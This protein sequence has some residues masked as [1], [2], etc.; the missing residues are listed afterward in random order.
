MSENT[1]PRRLFEFLREL[2]WLSVKHGIVI[3]GR[4]ELEFRDSL[5]GGYAINPNNEGPEFGW[6]EKRDG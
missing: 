5:D 4:P 1:K 6:M 2:T 3:E